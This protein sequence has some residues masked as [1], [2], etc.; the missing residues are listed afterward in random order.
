MVYPKELMRKKE[1]LELGFPE[2][3]IDRA[4]AAPGQR[5]AFK[6]NPSKKNSPYIFDTPKFEKWRKEDEEQQIKAR[7]MRKHVM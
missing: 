2:S 1:L 7:K 5:F 3:Y 4:I 6:V